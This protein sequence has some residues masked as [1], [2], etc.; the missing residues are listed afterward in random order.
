MLLQEMLASVSSILHVS[1]L[2]MGRLLEARYF[3][4][5]A[6]G[7]AGTRTMNLLFRLMT[8]QTRP[9]G[10]WKLLDLGKVLCEY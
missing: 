4:A 10:F 8:S 3:A 7:W 9:F 2:S 1:T 6:S 5:G